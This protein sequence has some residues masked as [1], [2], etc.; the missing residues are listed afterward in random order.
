MLGLL[1]SNKIFMSSKPVDMRKGFDGLMAIVRNEC[2]R[3]GYDV[4][5]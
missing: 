2:N 1:S 4:Y 3:T 5:A